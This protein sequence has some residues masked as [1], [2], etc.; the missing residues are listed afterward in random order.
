LADCRRCRFFIPL[1]RMDHDS[2]V[3]A[4]K[5]LQWMQ[6]NGKRQGHKILG[7]CSRYER[8]VTYYVGRCTGFSPYADRPAAKS[9]LDYLRGS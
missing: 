7:W 1:G 3:R 5:W 2:I 6:K 4:E 9:I 8:P